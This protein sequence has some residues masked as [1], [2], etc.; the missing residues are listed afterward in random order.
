MLVDST[1]V[2]FINIISSSSGFKKKYDLYLLFVNR[3][4]IYG[5]DE[6]GENN[7]SK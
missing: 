1:S 6:D 7:Q 2:V 3:G 5:L 4:L